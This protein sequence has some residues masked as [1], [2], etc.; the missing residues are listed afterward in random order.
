[1]AFARGGGKVLSVTVSST[2][3]SMVATGVRAPV[4][5]SMA[6]EPAYALRDPAKTQKTSE[7]DDVLR[8]VLVN[9]SQKMLRRHTVAHCHTYAAT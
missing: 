7:L 8:I 4:K 6:Y 1:M 3:R 5:N 2:V 9:T